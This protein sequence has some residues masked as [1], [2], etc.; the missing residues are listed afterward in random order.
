ML[1]PV[2]VENLIIEIRDHY[3]AQFRDFAA[4][5]RAEGEDGSTEVKFEV[6]DPGSAFRGLIVV[7][8]ITSGED[9]VA[10]DFDPEQMLSFNR[11]EGLVNDMALELEGLRWDGAVLRH[12]LPDAAPALE[13]WFER[14]FD[15]DEL[16]LDPE[17]ELSENIHALYVE[18]GELQVDFGT[19]PAEAFWELLGTLSAAGAA[20]VV[21]SG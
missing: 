14:W 7:D 13:D 1:E 16:R 4:R 18:P 9:I 15:P 12:D 11:I 5:M 21:V 10:S 17:A 3:V 20:R 6:P 8:H 2:E 19:A